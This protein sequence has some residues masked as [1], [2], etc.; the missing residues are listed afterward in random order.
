MFVYI[1]AVPIKN[2]LIKIKNGFRVTEKIPEVMSLPELFLSNPIRHDFPKATKA[3]I[4]TSNPENI[5]IVPSTFNTKE[6]STI[7]DTASGKMV[8]EKCAA[9]L[10]I[11]YNHKINIAIKTNLVKVFNPPFSLG[12][13][14]TFVPVL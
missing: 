5:D 12:V 14:N 9:F 1:K 3:R 7:F 2:K 4:K 8:N 11:S 10:T 6:S 13:T